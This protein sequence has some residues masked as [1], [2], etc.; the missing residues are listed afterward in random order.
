M[1]NRLRLG[2]DGRKRGVGLGTGLRWHDMGQEKEA[3]L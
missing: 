2:K 3:R 1:G